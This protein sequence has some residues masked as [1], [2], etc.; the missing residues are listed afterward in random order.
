MPLT[1]P[2]QPMQ[3]DCP[4]CL[5]R[6]QVTASGK[7]RIFSTVWYGLKREVGQKLR[8]RLRGV[9][10]LFSGAQEDEVLRAAAV[11]GETFRLSG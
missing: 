9:A 3:C 4:L 11:F 5:W 8:E 10:A 7:T 2:E 1:E 6:L